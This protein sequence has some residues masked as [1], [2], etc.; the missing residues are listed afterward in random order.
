MAGGLA[1]LHE[2][3]VRRLNPTHS[4]SLG[5]GTPTFFRGNQLRLRNSPGTPRGVYTLNGKKVEVAVKQM[6]AGK[7]VEQRSAF[8]NPEA[9]DLYWD[10]PELQGF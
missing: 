10:I 4:H 7:A 5:A 3:C 6:I 1:T 2:L 8:L 9:L